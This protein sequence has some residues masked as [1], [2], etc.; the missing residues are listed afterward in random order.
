MDVEVNVDIDRY[1]CCFLGGSKSVQ[2]Q[3]NGTEAVMVLY[4][5]IPNERAL[6]N[7]EVERGNRLSHPRRCQDREC[8]ALKFIQKPGAGRAVG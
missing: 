2:V 3:H 4:F 1:F 8:S 7:V 5:I 6:F